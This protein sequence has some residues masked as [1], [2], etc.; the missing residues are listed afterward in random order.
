[1][2]RLEPG[3]LLAGGE[4]VQ[5]T[6]LAANSANGVIIQGFLLSVGISQWNCQGADSD[7]SLFSKFCRKRPMK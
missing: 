2:A 4:E 6:T 5:P 7:Q 1:M 3:T